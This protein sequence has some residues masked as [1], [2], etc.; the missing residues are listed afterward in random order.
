MTTPKTV[1]TII[2]RQFDALAG[3]R[4]HGEDH[5]RRLAARLPAIMLWGPPGIGKSALL[6]SIADA[7]GVEFVDVRLAQREPVDMR[8]LPVPEGDSVRWL[9]SSEWPRDPQ[10]QGIILFDELSAADR[11]LQVAAYEFILDR[12]LGDMYE[13][14]PGW[15]VVG[16]GNR[17][18]DRAVATGMS[19]ALANRFLHLEMKADVA[20]WLE[21]ARTADI[22][23]SILTHIELNPGQLFCMD[24]TAAERGWPSPRS[25]ERLNTMLPLIADLNEGE[26]SS[27]FAG[28]IG[29][30]AATLFMHTQKTLD[31]RT[32]SDSV[33]EGPGLLEVLSGRT[34]WVPP[35]TADQA[36][37][38]LAAMAQLLPP[39]PPAS[40]TPSKEL[41]IYM[42]CLL[43]ASDVVG[44]AG[45]VELLRNQPF[46]ALSMHRSRH[47]GALIEKYEP[48]LTASSP[49]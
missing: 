7:R 24:S 6:R 8:G 40:V 14:P 41:S 44:A 5:A 46:A 30:K 10:S 45:M 19:S 38:Q 21:W 4:A 12:R 37:A 49:N 23:Q 36:R 25:W 48:L 29:T 32:P 33:D 1:T 17:T 15:L 3:A 31:T 9:V 18:E 22:D 34:R 13:L 28:L 42:D 27:V 20:S 26:R 11:T 43:R 47:F 35:R 39:S 2:E 16:A